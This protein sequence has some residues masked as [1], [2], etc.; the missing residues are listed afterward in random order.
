[1]V[2]AGGQ[3]PIITGLTIL[4]QTIDICKHHANLCLN[5]RCIPTVSSYRCE[6]NMG[7][8]QDANGDCIELMVSTKSV[9][10]LTN[11]HQI[12]ALMEIVLTHLDPITVNVTLDSK[13][14]LRSKR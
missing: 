11:A 12:P 6:C 10:M 1:G 2:G 3:G 7:Y 5:G 13:G 8:K 9:N 14:L 4:N